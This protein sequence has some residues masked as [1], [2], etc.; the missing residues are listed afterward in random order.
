MGDEVAKPVKKRPKMA[1]PAQ[2]AATPASA[3][4]VGEEESRSKEEKDGGAEA[5]DAKKK[6][7][8]WAGKAAIAKKAAK[9]ASTAEGKEAT[10]EELPGTPQNLKVKITGD[11]PNE[12]QLRKTFTGLCWLKLTKPSPGDLA[13]LEPGDWICS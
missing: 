4:E 9:P 13:S 8:K 5:E 3:A 12:A 1:E 7:P 10:E 6:P 11:E 2:K